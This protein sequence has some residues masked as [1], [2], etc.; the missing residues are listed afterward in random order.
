MNAESAA[1]GLPRLLYV[2]EVPVEASFAGALLLH[3]LLGGYPAGRLGIAERSA[4]PTP[5]HL[6]VGAG[7][8]FTIETALWPPPRRSRLLTAW[9]AA[10]LLAAAYTP[11][12]A[13]RVEDL[14]RAW[15]ADAILTIAQ[16]H[17]WLA[18]AKAAR[19]LKL[20]LHLVVHD[21]PAAT[22]SI[23]A[24]MS[25][26]RQRFFGAVYRQA[27][28]RLCVSP[29]MV[30]AYAAEF[31]PTGTVLYPCCGEDSPAPILRTGRIPSKSARFVIAYAGSL[32]SQGYRRLVRLLAEAVGPLGGQMDLYVPE[33]TA[34]HFA[35]SEVAAGNVHFRGFLPPAQLAETIAGSGTAVLF[36]PASFEEEER[37]SMQTLFPSKIADYAAMGLPILIWGPEYSSAV[38]WSRE[39]PDSAAVC[40]EE[41]CSETFRALLVRLRDD[42][43]WR[44]SLA[45]GALR[46]G[47]QCF[48]LA[49]ARGILYDAVTQGSLSRSDVLGPR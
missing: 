41:N 12:L 42:A 39:F 18:A 21:D 10:H 43:A 23:P 24:F 26:L 46:A 4:G 28:S 9:K 17:I 44:H 7:E 13:L 19:R 35:R 37:Q 25:P 5:A 8:Y 49:R 38:R 40:E 27:A 30:E 36:S 22:K 15:K 11:W 29:G 32:W 34:G 47:Q 20:P 2:G 16:G 3:R 33:G 6:R 14:A 31:G 1:T 45:E 48:T